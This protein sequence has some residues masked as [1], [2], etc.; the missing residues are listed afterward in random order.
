MLLGPSKGFRAKFAAWAPAALLGARQPHGIRGLTYINVSHTD[1]D[2]PDHFSW[3][4]KNALRSVYFIHDLIPIRYPE[5]SRP[6]AVARHTRRVRLALCNADQIITGSQ[7]V[8]DD[9]AAY[10]A[11]EALP[12][13]HITVSSIAGEGFSPVKQ[14]NERPPYFICVGTIEPRK[15]HRF[16]F[17]V[18]DQLAL[19][20]GGA[21]PRL[22][23]VGQT[24]PMTGGILSRLASH[25]HIELRGRC[26][27][28]ELADLMNDCTALLM[29]SLAEGFGLPVT[30]A[31]ALGTRVIASDTAVFHEI[32]QGM[33]QLIDP[34]DADAWA[35]T[36]AQLALEPHSSASDEQ[37]R[38][39]RA[40]RFFPPTWGAHFTAIDRAIAP[41]QSRPALK[42]NAACESSLA[43]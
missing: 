15:N 43:A 4:A 17:D 34:S 13:A 23:M 31:L 29:P 18:W 16:L 5:L 40:A 7:T 42:S 24:G 10:A 6:R 11:K 3:V 37:A 1:F 28:E 26:S 12:A 14:A 27:D 30:E 32:S 25:S 22:V 2:L 36:I 39:D 8:A 19:L 21:T 35:N 38:T 9:L 20:L 33:A 41:P